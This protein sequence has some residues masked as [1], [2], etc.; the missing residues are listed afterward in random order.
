MIS[1]KNSILLTLGL[2]VVVENIILITEI[3]CP[4]LKNCPGHIMLGTKLY[5]K[6]V[7]W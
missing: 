5:L 2:I 6:L 3:Y 4:D 1:N 7:E